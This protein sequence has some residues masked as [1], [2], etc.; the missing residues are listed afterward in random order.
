M[1]FA[2]YQN[3]GCGR[4]SLE[5]G[6]ELLVGGA[7]AACD[8]DLLAVAA[9]AEA[10]LLLEEDTDRRADK[11]VAADS[12]G[13][14]VE[15]VDEALGDA[16]KFVALGLLFE[17]LLAEL[18]ATED[19][20]LLEGGDVRDAL[21]GAHLLVGAQEGVVSQV[22]QSLGNNGS[23]SGGDGKGKGDGFHLFVI[24]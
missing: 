9:V 7:E 1:G 2:H 16:L 5:K 11:G 8:G 24:V 14:F 23:G 19:G 18:M 4:H 21:E 6:F 3:G 17:H 15:R 22:Q 12:L 13:G 10:M 20:D